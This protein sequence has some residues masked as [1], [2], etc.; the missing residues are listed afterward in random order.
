M[1]HSERRIVGVVVTNVSVFKGA[2][3]TGCP[4]FRWTTF[5]GQGVAATTWLEM[6]VANNHAAFGI[7][8][9]RLEDICALTS[10][11]ALTP[12]KLIEKQG[13]AMVFEAKTEYEAWEVHT[14]LM[15]GGLTSEI[16]T[17]VHGEE[18]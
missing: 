16:R 8:A 17:R 6:V 18:A 7:N 9:L 1:P 10:Q 4:D 15:Q 3:T 5:T 11:G 2:G 13:E 14:K 12:I